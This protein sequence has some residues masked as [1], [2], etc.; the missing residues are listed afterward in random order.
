MPYRYTKKQTVFAQLLEVNALILLWPVVLFKRARSHSAKRI[1]LVEPFQMGDVLSLTPMLA[2]LLRHFPSA[3]IYVLTKSSSG[4]ILEYDSRV[5]KVI[6]IDFP[7]SDYGYKQNKIGRIALAIRD[8]V[9]LGYY[10]FDIGLDTRGDIRSQ[11]LL[12]LAGCQWRVGYQNYLHSNLSVKGWLLTHRLKQSK[13]QHRYLWNLEL[14]TQIGLNENELYPIQFPSF[15]PDQLKETVVMESES[16]VIHTG[17]GWEF[18]RW[19]EAKWVELIKQLSEKS[20][21]GIVVIGGPGEKEIVDRI[22]KEVNRYASERKIQFRITTLTEMVALIKNCHQFIG[23]DSGPM[24]LAVCLNKPVIALFGPGDSAMWKPLNNDSSYIH[25]I[26]KFSCNPC[27]QTVC[28]FPKKSCMEEIE[29]E[30]IT[31]LLLI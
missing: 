21:R 1:L 13:Y 17:G 16:V 23:L 6:K 11:I 18:K 31:K 26:E 22:R 25:K 3:E 30:E 9:R 19:S 28:G 14:L 4:S 15:K 27:M 7:W 29:V 24:N 5:K 8:T 10:Q 12:T 20:D 2:P